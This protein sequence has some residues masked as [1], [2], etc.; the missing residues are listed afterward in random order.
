MKYIQSE[1]LIFFKI[2]FLALYE[3]SFM[4]GCSKNILWFSRSN[5]CFLSSD[6]FA[7]IIKN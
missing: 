5:K 6:S 3:V 4:I 7:S 2:Y 1:K